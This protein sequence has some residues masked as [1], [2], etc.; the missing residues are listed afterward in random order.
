MQQVVRQSD[1]L[2]SPS[3]AEDHSAQPAPLPATP[4]AE[5]IAEMWANDP[6]FA[7]WQQA[8]RMADLF[9]RPR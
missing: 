2:T 5:L 6:E 8:E 9:G 7:D 4:M 1:R 3:T